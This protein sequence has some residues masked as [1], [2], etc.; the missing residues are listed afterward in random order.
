MTTIGTRVRII[1]ATNIHYLQTGVVTAVSGTGR[2][3]VRA[4][5]DGVTDLFAPRDLAPFTA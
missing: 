5:T 3:Q 1:D 2:V 4:D